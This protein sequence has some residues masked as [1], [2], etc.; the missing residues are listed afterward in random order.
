MIRVDEY[1]QNIRPHIPDNGIKMDP[2]IPKTNCF[3]PP[4]ISVQSM[5]IV[6]HI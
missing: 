5:A 3:Q 4:N 2:K 1:Y 6:R